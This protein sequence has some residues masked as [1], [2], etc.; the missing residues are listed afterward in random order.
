MRLVRLTEA[1]DEEW[2]EEPCSSAEHLVAVEGGGDEEE[3][4]KDGCG[5]D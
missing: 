1:S 2:N 5:G 3:D 4:D